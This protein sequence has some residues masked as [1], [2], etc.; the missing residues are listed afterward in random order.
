MVL[1]LVSGIIF[2]LVARSSVRMRNFGLES[3]FFANLN[4]KEDMARRQAPV[5]ASIK[6]KMEGYDVHIE[7][8]SISA[9][10]TFVGQKMKDIPFRAQT[11]TNIVKI[12]RG[13]SAIIIPGGEVV[14]YPGDRLLAVG[15][16]EQIEALKAMVEGSVPPSV[17]D[18]ADDSGFDVLA[19]P[20]SKE[21]YLC[22]RTLKSVNM[23]EYRCMVISVLRNGNMITNP[24]P[25]L[26]F[27][28][29][30]TVW[31]AG[32]LTSANFLAQSV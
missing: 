22:G 23:R 18:P 3:K 28:E 26:E 30:D 9:D 4:E 21:S 2:F 1:L 15:T 24:R 10:S 12:S 8:L 14:I 13:S 6:A 32:E 25:E 31:I 20:I 7:S 29:G 16:T 19:V 11:G 5:T 17:E 27:Q